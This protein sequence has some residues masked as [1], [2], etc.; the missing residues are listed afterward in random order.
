MQTPLGEKRRE[1]LWKNLA[2]FGEKCPQFFTDGRKIQSPIIPIILGETAKAL[3]AAERLMAEGI[4]VP[5]I[6]FPTV[7]KDA[8]RLRITMTAAHTEEQIIDLCAALRGI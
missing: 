7:A 1:Q 6:R 3:E 8:A 4:Y 2:L 5:A